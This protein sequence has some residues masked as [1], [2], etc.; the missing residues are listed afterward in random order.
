MLEGDRFPG[1]T[2]VAIIDTRDKDM[3]DSCLGWLVDTR[4]SLGFG[5]LVIETC[6]PWKFP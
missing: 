2:Y 5:A 1:L 4:Y 6:S 3:D